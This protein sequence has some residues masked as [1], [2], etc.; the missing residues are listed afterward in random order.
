MKITFHLIA[1]ETGY[2]EIPFSLMSRF[3]FE[4]SRFSLLAGD[5]KRVFIDDGDYDLFMRSIE[6]DPVAEKIRACPTREWEFT[7]DFEQHIGDYRVLS[8]R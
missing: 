6:G 5:G 8:C 2:L 3:G 1:G 7:E 4:S